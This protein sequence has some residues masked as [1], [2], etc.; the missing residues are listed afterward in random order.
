MNEFSHQPVLLDEVLEGLSIKPRGTYIDGTF[1]RGGHA[2]RIVEK[3]DDQGRL[4]VMDKDPQAIA[5]AR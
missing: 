1:G 2:S 5:A 3:L 4:L